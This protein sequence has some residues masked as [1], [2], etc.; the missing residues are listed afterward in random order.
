DDR[1]RDELSREAHLPDQ[2]G[3]VEE[4]T[5]SRLEGRR[6]EDP[7]RE[8]G[9]QVERVVRDVVRKEN[10]EDEEVD[11]QE[12][13]RVDEPPRDPEHRPAVARMEVAPEE[14]REQLAVANEVGVDGH[15][16]Q[17]RGGARS[18]TLRRA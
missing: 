12:G 6:E 1:E 10:T 3:A 15:R 7:A 16:A 17:C 9:K 4:R 14:V 18:S 2:L 11:R 8:P 5:R 13:E